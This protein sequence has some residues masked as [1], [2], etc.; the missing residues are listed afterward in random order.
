MADRGGWFSGSRSLGHVAQAVAAYGIFFFSRLLPFAA[1]SSFGGWAG[2]AVGP[3]LSA[4]KLARKNLERAF[5]EKTTGEIGNII[6]GMWDNLGR[7][8]F[9]YPHLDKLKIYDGDIA[10]VTGAERIDALK[11]DGKPGIFFAGHLANWEIQALSVAR[12][13]LPINL[14]YRAPNNPLM[15]GI[16]RHRRQSDGELIAKGPQG[17]RRSLALLKEGGHLGILV[18]Q[19]MNDGI[20]VPFFGRDAMTAPALAHFALKFQCPVV[21][22][23]VV[24][25]HGAHFH[26]IFH[27]PMKISST[28]DT[29]ADAAAIMERINGIIEEWIRE[30]PEQWLWVHNRWPD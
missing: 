4:S 8:A 14:I 28:G 25:T 29:R 21:P 27:E 9:E 26:V 19:K 24:R 13:G 5:P 18:D 15:E 17:A 30:H 16:F 23:Q 3:R 12:R 7:T 11:N 2:R 1:A 10:E 20:A 6:T 22:V